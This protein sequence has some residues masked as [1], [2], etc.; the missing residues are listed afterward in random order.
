ML[1][2]RRGGLLIHATCTTGSL[3][4][5]P[6]LHPRCHATLGL[7]PHS[8][9]LFVVS[10]LST[11]GFTDS[12]KA[13]VGLIKRSVISSLFRSLTPTAGSGSSDKANE[14][15]AD[16]WVDFLM[17]ECTHSSHTG[18][19]SV[20]ATTTTATATAPAARGATASTPPLPLSVVTS[21]APPP[22]LPSGTAPALSTRA[23]MSVLDRD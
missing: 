5:Q 11:Q 14:S 8:L 19:P 23:L 18:G 20:A 15:L 4:T 22:A 21:Q 3:S 2:R 1:V 12:E 10:P 7:A 17:E 6:Q 9:R 13:D 16:A